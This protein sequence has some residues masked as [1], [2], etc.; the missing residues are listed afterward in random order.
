MRI[1]VNRIT[2]KVRF[3]RVDVLGLEHLKMIKFYKEDAI[4]AIKRNI[5]PE[6][7]VIIKFPLFAYIYSPDEEE[8]EIHP[9]RVFNDVPV[10]DFKDAFKH[11]RASKSSVI[12]KRKFEY[13]NRRVIKKGFRTLTL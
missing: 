11:M 9:S 6:S 5:R 12:R 10:I 13:Q 8:L 7:D 1:E 3:R 4:A 2:K